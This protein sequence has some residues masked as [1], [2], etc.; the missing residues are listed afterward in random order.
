[1]GQSGVDAQGRVRNA[2]GVFRRR[3]RSAETCSPSGDQTTGDD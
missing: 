3:E 2:E 1:M